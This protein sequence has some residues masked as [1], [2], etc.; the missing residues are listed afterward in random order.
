MDTDQLREIAVKMHGFMVIEGLRNM[1]VRKPW[2][3]TEIKDYK[4][5]HVKNVDAV[6][7]ITDGTCLIYTVHEGSSSMGK[8]SVFS[9]PVKWLKGVVDYEIPK[10]ER[11]E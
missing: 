11:I 3:T 1:T 2:G 7:D 5:T 9:G 8:S 10:D 4:T 6:I